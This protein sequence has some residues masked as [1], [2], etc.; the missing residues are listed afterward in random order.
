MG[1][2]LI[3][4]NPK[5]CTTSNP[6]YH[7]PP[8]HHLHSPQ[9]SPKALISSFTPQKKCRISPSI[10]PSVQIHFAEILRKR[11]VHRSSMSLDGVRT[12]GAPD[13]R[14]EQAIGPQS[15]HANGSA[16]VPVLQNGAAAAPPTYLT[17][18]LRLNPN[19]DHRP[20]S[21]EDLELEFSPSIF[22]SLER[23]LPPNLLHQTRDVKVNYMREI[24]L[25]YYPESERIRVNV[26]TQLSSI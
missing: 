22:S 26:L 6:R 19:S 17:H 5:F 9:K 12:P 13:G 8:H 3:S 11:I 2:T 25:R 18:R 16:I 1:W 4:Y 14:P 21:Y 23:Y 24:L 10:T 7:H 15:V 20:D